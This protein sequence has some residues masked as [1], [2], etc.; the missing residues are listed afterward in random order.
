MAYPNFGKVKTI[1]L[2]IDND[3]TYSIETYKKD[4]GIDLRD[5]FELD[6]GYIKFKNNIKNCLVLINDNHAFSQSD[7]ALQPIKET[8]KQQYDPDS[9]QNAK[10][11]L[12]IDLAET[13]GISLLIQY[14]DDFLIDNL[15]ISEVD[16]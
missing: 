5:I 8:K 2:P 15:I 13:Y 4:Y 1:V 10:L 16:Y 6:D 14:T 9:S 12:Y 3:K 11:D 7:Y